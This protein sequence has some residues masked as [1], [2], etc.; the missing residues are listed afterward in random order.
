MIGVGV[1]SQTVRLRNPGLYS[2]Q[3]ASRWWPLAV[4]SCNFDFV[5]IN[6]CGIYIKSTRTQVLRRE[7]ILDFIECLRHQQ[8]NNTGMTSERRKH[9]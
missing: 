8:Q 6:A 3:S 1:G 2:K 7:F 5:A 9:R 4:W